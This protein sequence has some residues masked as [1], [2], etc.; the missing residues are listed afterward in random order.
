MWSLTSDRIGKRLARV[1]PNANHC[2]NHETEQHSQQSGKYGFLQLGTVQHEEL[3]S[4]DGS[5]VTFANS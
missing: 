2:V 4:V 5:S 1:G 3:C